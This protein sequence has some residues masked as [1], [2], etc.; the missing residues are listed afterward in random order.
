MTEVFVACDYPRA[1]MDTIIKGE[2]EREREGNFIQNRTI[3]IKGR[4]I[5]GRKRR[6]R[7][8]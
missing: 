2:R 6:K 7:T 8:Q 3:D 1:H 4:E 5:N